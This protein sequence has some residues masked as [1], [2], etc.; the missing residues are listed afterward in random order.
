MQKVVGYLLFTGRFSRERTYTYVPSPPQRLEK[1][2]PNDPRRG[3]L[4]AVNSVDGRGFVQTISFLFGAADL[5]QPYHS[6][7]CRCVRTLKLQACC[8]LDLQ[9]AQRALLS[10]KVREA[11][12]RQIPRRVESLKY[13][14]GLKSL[15]TARSSHHVG[16]ASLHYLPDPKSYDAAGG[17]CT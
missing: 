12:S 9:L 14:D 11:R 8:L 10:H 15:G 4:G 7:P 5:K 1:F 2:C 17:C 13:N 16:T 6:F 3:H